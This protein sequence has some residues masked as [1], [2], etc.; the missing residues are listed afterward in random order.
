MDRNS[1][2]ALKLENILL[3]NKSFKIGHFASGISAQTIGGI[4]DGESNE[5][6]LKPPELLS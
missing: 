4:G 3:G 1:Y 6:M 5:M 2:R